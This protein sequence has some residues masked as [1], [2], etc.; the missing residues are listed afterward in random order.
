MTAYYWVIFNFCRHHTLCIERERLINWNLEEQNSTHDFN[1]SENWQSNC[2]SDTLGE[3][4]ILVTGNY[5]LRVMI[6]LPVLIVT[7]RKSVFVNDDKILGGWPLAS[8]FSKRTVFPPLGIIQR[9]TKLLKNYFYSAF[10][11]PIGIDVITNFVPW[12]LIL[13]NTCNFFV[14]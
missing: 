5:Q 11:W 9:R 4:M 12:K 8:D 6:S 14:Q 1:V 13:L 7:S 10:K 3:L 2:V